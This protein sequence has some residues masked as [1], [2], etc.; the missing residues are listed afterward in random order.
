MK[1]I[2]LDVSDE[3]KNVVKKIA[4]NDKHFVNQLVLSKNILRYMNTEPKGLIQ[5]IK[6]SFRDKYVEKKVLKALDG[7]D[8]KW[9]YIVSK[10]FEY[11]KYLYNKLQNLL[12]MKLVA[13]SEMDSNIFKYI[14]EYLE[15]NSKVKKHELKTLVVSNLS[16]NINF[17][18]IENLLKEH[19]MVNIYLKEKPSGYVLN[20]IKQINKAYGTMVEVIKKERKALTEY[21]VVYFVD[22]I[23]ENSQRLR[24]NKTALVLDKN[25]LINDKYNSS[26]VFLEEFLLKE[27]TLEDNIQHLIQKYNKL[28][29]ATV[30]RKITN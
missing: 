25:D 23:K 30:I 17:T 21:N 20:K 3:Q 9:S 19:K 26:I 1:F 24:L 22:D 15:N 27:N 13:A 16:K 8:K 29:L 6:Y 18:L 11:D 7:Y 2:L 28:E 5:K 4:I 10:D 12:G 14:E